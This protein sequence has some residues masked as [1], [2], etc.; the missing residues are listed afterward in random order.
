MNEQ[1]SFYCVACDVAVLWI[2][3]LERGWKLKKGFPLINEQF[4]FEWVPC[5][6]ALLLIYQTERR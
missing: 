1:F 4:S 3:Q 5:E 6:V 2:N